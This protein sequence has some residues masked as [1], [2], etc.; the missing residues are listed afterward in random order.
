MRLVH[1]MVGGYT[2]GEMCWCLPLFVRRPDGYCYIVHR[3]HDMTGI[4]P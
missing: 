1:R 3:R 2:L 4:E